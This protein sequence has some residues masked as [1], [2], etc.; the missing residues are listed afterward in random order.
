MGARLGRP[1]RADE[2]WLR[3]GL[4]LDGIDELLRGFLTRRR[5]RVHAPEET[6]VLVR[7]DRGGLAWLVVVTPDEPVATTRLDLTDHAGDEGHE[8]PE[9]DHEL[10]GSPVELY[11]QLWNRGAAPAEVSDPGSTEAWWRR[12][13][14]VNWA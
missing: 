7:P 13:V 5:Q 9:A 8:V 4:A 2:T 6:R 3:D 11:L 1:A 10:V 12:T 14:T